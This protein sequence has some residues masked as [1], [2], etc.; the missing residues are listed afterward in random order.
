M[1]ENFLTNPDGADAR[2][3]TGTSNLSTGDIEVVQDE[4]VCQQ[5]NQEYSGEELSQ[6]YDVTY[7]KA[8]NF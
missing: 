8:G 3:E 1:V 4:G 6:N 2:E 5:L 7:Y